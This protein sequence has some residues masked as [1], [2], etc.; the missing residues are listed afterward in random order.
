[1]ARPRTLCLVAHYF[2]APEDSVAALAACTNVAA[3]AHREQVVKRTVAWLKRLSAC[4]DM[5]IVIGGVRGKNLLPLDIDYTGELET[6]WHILWRLFADAQRQ[7]DNYEYLLVLEDDIL[8]PRHTIERMLAAGRE[9]EDVR[10]AIFPNRIEFLRGFPVVPDLIALP[11]W[12][13]QTINWRSKTW[14]RAKNPHSAILF[15]GRHQ[16]EEFRKV[17]FSR[18]HITIGEYTT[19]AFER[20]HSG[21]S[22]FRE[23]TR[24]PVHCVIH[25]D[26]W[27]RRK[28]GQFGFGSLVRSHLALYETA[29]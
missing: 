14:Y 29:Q 5:D 18:P 3:Q 13:A 12:T 21:Y 9:L 27:C 11:G 7:L 22:L 28:L 15:L 17:D 25:Q 19:S 2:G 20:A 6:H 24:F 10:H 26:G 4:L 1:M 23:R 8:V 16:S